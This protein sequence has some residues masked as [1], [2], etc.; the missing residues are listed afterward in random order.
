MLASPSGAPHGTAATT[1]PAL[2][3]VRRARRP[4][5]AVE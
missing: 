2:A 5:R 1:L 4:A 3:M